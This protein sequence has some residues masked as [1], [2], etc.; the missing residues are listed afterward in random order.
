MSATRTVAPAVE[1]AAQAFVEATANPPFL[2]EL[3][4]AEGRKAVDDVQTSD[5]AKPAAVSL[6]LRRLPP[7]ARGQERGAGRPPAPSLSARALRAG[8]PIS[9]GHD[10][11][12][13]AACRGRAGA[14][15]R[16][17]SG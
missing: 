14:G 16:V 5:I 17:Q 9:A 7:G 3:L 15:V 12:G 13:S 8:R 10:M 2:F 1:P 4:P 6:R 11:P